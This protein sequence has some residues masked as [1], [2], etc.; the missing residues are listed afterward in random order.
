[1]LLA[2]GGLATAVVIGP[3]APGAGREHRDEAQFVA[4]VNEFFGSNI[5]RPDMS[6]RVFIAE[7]DRACEWLSEEPVVSGEAPDQTEYPTFR[8]F[9]REVPPPDVW[10]MPSGPLSVRGSVVYDAWNYLCPQVREHHIW[11]PPPGYGD[12]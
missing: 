6:N 3:S 7:G 10:P 9:F 1:M 2:G 12:D 4:H 11:T 8:R 5:P